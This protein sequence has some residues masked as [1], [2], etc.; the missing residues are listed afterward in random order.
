MERLFAYLENNSESAS[1]RNQFFEML[2]ESEDDGNQKDYIS[3]SV[4]VGALLDAKYN[5][6]MSSGIPEA[7]L[8]GELLA[9]AIQSERPNIRRHKKVR[10]NDPCPCGSGKKFKKCCQGNGVFD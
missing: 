3:K 9:D 8:L 4:F 6:V 5:P 10:R 7:D 2:S 1:V